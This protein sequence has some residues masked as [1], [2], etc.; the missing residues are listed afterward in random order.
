MIRELMIPLLAIL[1]MGQLEA[2]ADDNSSKPP[3]SSS[4]L[5][6]C[7]AKNVAAREMFRAQMVAAAENPGPIGGYSIEQLG[8]LAIKHDEKQQDLATKLDE[9]IEGN[10]WSSDQFDLRFEA[11][12]LRF[13]SQQE[14][15]FSTFSAEKDGI[16]YLEYMVN[17]GVEGVMCHAK[18]VYGSGQFSDGE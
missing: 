13:F 7:F 9:V 6:L 5:M 4:E 17:T 8:N 1:S 15:L 14:A 18:L 3:D 11:A 10:S 2:S 16:A 12:T